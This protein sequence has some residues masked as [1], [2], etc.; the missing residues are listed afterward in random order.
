MGESFATSDSFT[1]LVITLGNPNT[2]KS[3]LFNRLTG[4]RQKVS[5][6]PGVTVE[7]V[8]GYCDLNGQRIRLVDVPGTYSL[9][10]MSPDEMI[11]MDVLCGAI[12]ELGQPQAAVVVVDASNLRRNL[13]LTSQVLEVG[14]PIVI[15]LNMIDRLPRLGLEIDDAKLAERLDCPVI[16]IAATVGNGIDALKQALAETIRSASAPQIAINEEFTEAAQELVQQLSAL[17]TP[18]TQLEGSRALIDVGGYGEKRLIEAYGERASEQLTKL[19]KRLGGGR[20]LAT[21]ETRDRYSWIHSQLSD[22]ETGEANTQRTF[23]D[24]LDRFVNHPI[25]G[26]LL[27]ALVMATVFQAVFAWA[28]PLVEGINFL[29]GTLAI[30]TFNT[31]GDNVFSRFLTEGVIA[32]VGSVVVFLPQIMILF[33]FI[34]ALEDSGYMARAAFLMDRVMRGIG[35]SGQSFIPMLSSF[36]CAVPG[37]MGTRV[38]ANKYDRLATIMAAPFM[39][40]SA[41]LPVYSLLIAA[42]IP[43]VR[44]AHGWINAQGLILFALY[45]IGLLGGA[46]TAWL[47][48]RVFWTRTQS[49]FLLEMPPYRMPQLGTVFNKL[50]ARV[51]IFLKRAGTIIFMVAIVVWVLATFPTDPNFNESARGSGNATQQIETS[52]LGGISQ[53]VAPLFEPLGWDWKVTAAVVASFPARE[54]VIAVLGTIYAVGEKTDEGVATLTDRIRSAKHPNGTPVYTLPMVIGLMVFFAFCLQCAST[55]AVMRRETG[56]W[57]WPIAA[58]FYMTGLGYLGALAVYQTGT[59]LHF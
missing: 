20:D 56:T 36:A 21:I 40:C 59:W 48:G 8:S 46:F 39:T 10:A 15:A 58:W 25:T 54:A 17:S 41:R 51:V 45:L 52:Y 38:I 2:G 7:Q 9:S 44:Y 1:P 6:Y 50:M 34:I 14:L 22:V 33:A 27:F 18:I 53:S 16:P 23:S 35:L 19:R 3:T 47:I 55:M 31:F 57:R 30:Q 4:L 29:T 37:I 5:N 11:A 49:R 24:L 12:P 26:T 43:D 13:F 32:G 28:G 42:F